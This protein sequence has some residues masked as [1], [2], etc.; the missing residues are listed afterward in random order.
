[1]NAMFAEVVKATWSPVTIGLMIGGVVTIIGAASTAIVAVVRAVN[2]TKKAVVETKAK[3]E[4][5]ERKLDTITVLVDGRYSQVLNELAVVKGLLAD[6]TGT[7]G[8]RASAIHADDAAK[9]Q[10]AI[11]DNVNGKAAT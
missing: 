5:S 2:D 8:D 9:A 4:T 7:P 3:V 11:V 1:M 6:S 10:Q